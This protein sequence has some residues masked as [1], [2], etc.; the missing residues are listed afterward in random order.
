VLALHVDRKS[1]GGA[2]VLVDKPDIGVVERL[3][4][5]VV[6]APCLGPRG[7]DQGRKRRAERLG[8]VRRGTEESDVRKLVTDFVLL[9]SSK[10]RRSDDASRGAQALRISAMRSPMITQ[11]AWVLPVVTLGM[12]EPSAMRR[13]FTP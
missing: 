7:L 12:I 11:G 9:R 1:F 2:P 4:Q 3:M 5:V 8:L 13:F 6:E 10:R